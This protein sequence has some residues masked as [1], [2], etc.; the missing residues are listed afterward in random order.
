MLCLLEKFSKEQLKIQKNNKKIERQDEILI[1]LNH[2]SR[3]TVYQEL[4]GLI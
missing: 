2:V 1:V 3:V 4:W